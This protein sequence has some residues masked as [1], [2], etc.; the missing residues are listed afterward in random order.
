MTKYLITFLLTIFFA[1]CDNRKA[2]KI[3]ETKTDIPRLLTQTTLSYLDTLFE[4]GTSIS[5]KLTAKLDSNLFS[6]L[7]SW[8][9]Y[10]ESKIE[11]G[12]KLLFGK[13]LKSNF[14]SLYLS[15]ADTAFVKGQNRNGNSV[16]IN[17]GGLSFNRDTTEISTVL[18]VLFGEEIKSGWQEAIVFKKV[19]KVWTIKNRNIILEY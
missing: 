10:N 7:N 18:A 12:D 13:L 15:S 11:K 5:I 14:D 1:S 6:V 17:F 16:L 4:Q 3:V 9:L 2:S 19:D 8:I